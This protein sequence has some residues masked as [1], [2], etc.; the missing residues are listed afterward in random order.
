M[1]ALDLEHQM[2]KIKNFMKSNWLSLSHISI[3]EECNILINLVLVPPN[4]VGCT[5]GSDLLEG[6]WN[7]VTT[8]RMDIEHKISILLCLRS[9][10]S[11]RHQ[12]PVISIALLQE[13]YKVYQRA[14]EKKVYCV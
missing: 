8:G 13:T 11:D 7:T 9:I 3:P 6:N 4:N 5:G 10:H 14:R 12:F 1:A 2:G